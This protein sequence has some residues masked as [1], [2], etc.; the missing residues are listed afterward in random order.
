MIKPII[1]FTGYAAPDLIVVAQTIHDRM[2]KV[3]AFSDPPHTMADFQILITTADQALAQRASNAK[4]DVIA[5]QVARHALEGALSDLG[6]YVNT[7]AQGDAAIVESSGFPSYDTARAQSDAPPAAPENLVLRQGDLSGQMISRCKPD[8][9]RS[10]NEVQT[11]IGDPND[12]SNWKMAGIFSGGKATL[13]GLTP[14]TVYWVRVRTA[15]IKGVMGAWSDPAK[16][17]VT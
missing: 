16:M 2:S 7:K 6:G 11:C 4:A 1:D 5:F 3:A 14:G 8:R 17:M 15:G 9:P 10:V 12:E 13:S